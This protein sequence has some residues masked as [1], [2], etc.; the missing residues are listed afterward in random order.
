MSG[1]IL[2]GLSEEKIGRN[3]GLSSVGEPVCSAM[4][5]DADVSD[6]PDREAPMHGNALRQT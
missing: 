4:Y 5:F 2:V 6:D 1:G 3:I